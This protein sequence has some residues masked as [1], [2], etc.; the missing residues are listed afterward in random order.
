MRLLALTTSFPLRSGASA[1]VFVKRL[2]EQLPSSWRTDVACPADNQPA[3]A[4]VD[5][6][7]RM[8]VR[9]VRYGPRRWQVLAQQPGGIVPLLRAAP[10]CA[11]L[12]PVM[13]V[14]LWYRC[15]TASRNVDLLHANWA[16][17]GAIAAAAAACTGR[18]VVTTLRGDDVVRAEHSRLDRWLLHAAV[19]GSAAIAC[20]SAAM[21]DQL[22]RRYPARAAD[23]HVVLN[24]VDPSFLGVVR[25]PP[26]PAQ[27][28]VA[29][30]GSLIERK[31]F[32]V[33]I[34]AVSLMRGRD[35]VVVRIAG[36]GPEL[37]ALQK[38][39]AAAGLNDRVVFVGALPPE[40]IASFLA[41][42]DVFVLPSR[43]EGRPNA[44]IEAL[45]AGLP[46]IASDLPGIDGLVTAGINGWRVAIGDAGALAEA[47]D[48]AL[49][50]SE[51]RERRG[52]AARAGIAG[53][54]HGWN[55]TGVSYDRLFRSVLGAAN[56]GAA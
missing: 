16:V 53:A 39:V 40:R 30:V 32:D 24:G 7:G 51:D 46:V 19:R 36:S 38:R 43:S 49:T 4:A 44:A 3:T 15:V 6:A 47:L 5:C 52:A 9:P 2:Y 31:G 10:W 25:S 34:E 20:V 56:R 26:S 33:L 1:G 22:R 18:P 37:G 35:S 27:L 21:A 8:Q 14:A 42:A 28:R 48:Y 13:F 45:A 29:A 11:L 17:C 12:L 23:I 41:D 55:A 54:E 50:H